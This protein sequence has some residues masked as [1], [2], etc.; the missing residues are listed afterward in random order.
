[1]KEQLNDSRLLKTG[2]YINGG[3]VPAD[4]GSTLAVVNPASGAVV[5]EVARCGTSE[6]RRA[7]EAAEIAQKSWNST[8]AKERAAILRRWN[9]R[10][11]C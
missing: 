6:T 9:S 8:T 11:R 4:D 3:W 2:A 1:M 5:A 7:I 10:P